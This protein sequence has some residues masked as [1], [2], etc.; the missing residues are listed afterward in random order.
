MAGAPPL[1]LLGN[2]RVA[3]AFLEE[4][5][6]RGQQP[7]LVLLNDLPKQRQGDEM[8]AACAAA[9]IPV[10]AWSAEARLALLDWLSHHSNGWLFSIYFAHILDGEVLAAAGG[11][12]VNLHASLLPWCRGAHTNVWPLVEQAPAGITLHV[13]APT[14]DAGAVLAQEPVQVY[15]WDTAATLY[16][17]LEEAAGRLATQSWP[18][19]VR[20]AWPGTPQAGG[21]SVHRTRDLARL[22]QYD[23]DAHPEARRFYDLLRARTFPPHRGLKVVVDGKCVEARI[24][25]R[26]CSSE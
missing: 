22:D 13:M 23:L 2:G 6:R 9:R 15:P 5:V 1:V 3:L 8:R 20:A 25:L 24:E 19:A 7:G 12:A 11:R 4:A 16:T 21:G 17:R 18:E 26:E 14:V 10:L